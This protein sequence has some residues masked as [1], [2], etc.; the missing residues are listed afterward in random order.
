MRDRLHSFG[1][2]TEAVVGMVTFGTEENKIVDRDKNEPSAL[3]D[4]M[5][6]TDTY[7]YTWDKDSKWVDIAQYRQFY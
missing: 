7:C 3:V 2:S 5:H 4:I 6:P 1:Y